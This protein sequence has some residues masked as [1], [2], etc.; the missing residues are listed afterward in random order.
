[1]WSWTMSRG[2]VVAF[3]PIYEYI[4]TPSDQYIATIRQLDFQVSPDFQDLDNSVLFWVRFANS[5]SNTARFRLGVVTFRE[6]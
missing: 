1:M 3:S 6:E 5:G 4:P 2:A